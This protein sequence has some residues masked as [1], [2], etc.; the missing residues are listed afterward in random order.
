MPDKILRVTIYSTCFGQQLR[1]VVHFR[2]RNFVVGDLALLGGAIENSWLGQMRFLSTGQLQYNNIRV[3]VPNDDTLNPVDRPLIMPGLSQTVIGVVLPMAGVLR[4]KTADTSKRGVGRYY[5]PGM[6]MISVEQ[7]QWNFG[8]F[9]QMNSVCDS[10]EGS[11]RAEN[12]PT[13]FSLGITNKI[14]P[15]VAF[16]EMIEFLPRLYPGTQVRRQFF[17]G[18]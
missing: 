13:G 4:I 1:N 16:K 2:R 17:R 14:E 18:S 8:G 10:I 6:S 11:F 3:E 5:V 15:Q 9:Q 7:G 12:P